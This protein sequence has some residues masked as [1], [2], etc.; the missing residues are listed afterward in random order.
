MH[1]LHITSAYP[2]A[3]GGNEIHIKELAEQLYRRKCDVTVITTN[4]AS[5]RGFRHSDDRFPNLGTTIENGVTVI[6]IPIKD[7][8]RRLINKIIKIRGGWRTLQALLGDWLSMR[9]MAPATAGFFW[10]PL[11]TPA[12]CIIGI[13]I[14]NL[15]AYY[16]A[17][18]ARLRRVPFVMIPCIHT[19]KHDDLKPI[20]YR[21]L[22]LSE[23]IIALTPHEK[24]YLE[25]RGINKEK[26][27]VIGVGTNAYKNF[28]SK[29]RMSSE[30]FVVGFIGRP[31]EGKGLDTLVKAMRKVWTKIPNAKLVVAGP[32]PRSGDILDDSLGYLSTEERSK[33]TRVHDFSE[34]EK[35][36][37]FNS[38]DV[39]AMPSKVESFGI[40]YL[41]AWSY[42]LP[43]IGCWQ[44]ASSTLIDHGVNGPLNHYGDVDG[45][46]E[47]L[48]RL[49]Q[50]PQLRLAMGENGRKKVMRKYTWECIAE[51]VHN[52]CRSLNASR[53]SN[54]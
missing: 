36:S 8:F 49:A 23:A 52:L 45:L 53:S 12:D 44:G 15:P 7:P 26:I 28:H 1:I 35:S 40:V 31:V 42:K 33:V 43:V 37:I 27:H 46:A 17:F 9:S 41:E 14:Y 47:T 32:K 48:L 11:L 20:A 39:F 2:P 16:A 4:A 50:Q 18:A 19:E 34:E 29:S 54:A 5:I 30:Q 51:K 21:L 13:N 38:L 6:R 10:R 22:H 3:R 24:D 25:A